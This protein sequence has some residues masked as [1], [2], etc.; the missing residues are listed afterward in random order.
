MAT[1]E[2]GDRFVPRGRVLDSPALADK[3][4]LRSIARRE[5]AAVLADNEV[6]EVYDHESRVRY[7]LLGE[8]DGRRLHVVVAEDDIA[9]WLGSGQWLPGSEGGSAMSADEHFDGG[10][11]RPSVVAHRHVTEHEDGRVSAIVVKGVPALVCDVCEDAYYEPEV[12]DAVAALIAR[13]VVAPGEAVAIDYRT[14]D[15]A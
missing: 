4:V 8:P 9:A 15:A 13:T 11:L 5:I 12:T 10:R 7:V 14:A 2:V 1:F 3:M 6:I